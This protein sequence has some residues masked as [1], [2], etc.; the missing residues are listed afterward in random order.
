MHC[1]VDEHLKMSSGT[2]RDSSVL[3]D[4]HGEASFKKTKD[5]PTSGDRMINVDVEPEVRLSSSSSSR[6]KSFRNEYAGF[7]FQKEASISTIDV[8][9][10]SLINAADFFDQY[11][12][13]RKPCI[14]NGLPTSEGKTDGGVSLNITRKL[15]ED[16]AGDKT[17]Q[18]ERRFSQAE[19]F[20]HNR[21]AKRQLCLSI[22]AFLKAL[23]DNKNADDAVD[24]KENEM[25]YWSTQEDTDDPYNIPC[26][27]LVDHGFIPATVPHAGNLILS[28]CNLWMGSSEK[29]ASS[30][31][32]HDYHD[33]F[34]LLLQGKKRFRLF[35]PDCAPM[36]HVYGAIECIHAN[37]RISYIGNETRAD[38]VPIAELHRNGD[39]CDES[40]EE[41]DG[42]DDDGDD[43][44]EEEDIVIGKGFDYISD[45][46]EDEVASFCIHHGTHDD[47]DEIM[48]VT[49]KAGGK[50]KMGDRVSPLDNDVGDVDHPDSFSII[51]PC[52]ANPETLFKKYPDYKSCRQ[53]LT[54]LKAG[55]M[56]Y[57]PAGFFHEVTSYSNE[58]LAGDLATENPLAKCHMALNYWYHPPDALD[59]SNYESPYRDNFW[60]RE[61]EQSAPSIP[62]CAS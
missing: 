13:K 3:E 39:N 56:L 34:Y 31:L 32:H 4:T 29:G 25:Y 26:R 15:L 58:I 20:G 47:F 16:L 60:R 41:E 38:G 35:S 61:H 57:L 44:K 7:S 19:N 10:L 37:G 53:V 46:E 28:S 22:S 5:S 27:Q 36:L 1:T 6:Q 23:L 9:D 11:I 54:E 55:Q 40:V 49:T 18:V 12:R 42:D 21:T 45:D 52:E 14:L 2:K 48:G 17:I 62:K 30:G 51:N 24:K 8:L 33:N 43:D 59:Q 50:N